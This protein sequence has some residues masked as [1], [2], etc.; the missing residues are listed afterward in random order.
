[1]VI[2]KEDYDRLFPQGETIA[3]AGYG[4]DRKYIPPIAKPRTITELTYRNDALFWLPL[5]V[6]KYELL[7]DISSKLFDDRNDDRWDELRY[8]TKW[9]AGEMLMPS[10]ITMFYDPY[11]KAGREKMFQDYLFW[12]IQLL[13]EPFMVDWSDVLFGFFYFFPLIN[14]PLRIYCFYV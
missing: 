3:K 8:D 4:V 12:P 7:W 11:S 13:W 5:S 1:M 10:G 9:A 6:F 14:I 2:T